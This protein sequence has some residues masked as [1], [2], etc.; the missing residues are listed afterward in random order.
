MAGHSP[1]P[2]LSDWC[3]VLPPSTRDVDRV[4]PTVD[5]RGLNALR[6]REHADRSIRI[7]PRRSI[8]ARRRR[9]RR[10]RG[11]RHGVG[12]GGRA[13]DQIVEERQLRDDSQVVRNVN[14][15]IE[16]EPEIRTR[17]RLVVAGLVRGRCVAADVDRLSRVSVRLAVAVVERGG[18]E[19]GGVVARDVPVDCRALEGGIPTSEHEVMEKLGARSKISVEFNH[20]TRMPPP[21]V[22]KDLVGVWRHVLSGRATGGLPGS[23]VLRRCGMT[24]SRRSRFAP[25]RTHRRMRRFAAPLELPG[26]RGRLSRCRR[27]R[28]LGGSGFTGRGWRWRRRDRGLFRGCCPREKDERG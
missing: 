18:E 9:G 26:S 23:I 20:G 24:R 12:I 11:R 27:R 5:A 28:L 22:A 7:A 8:T 10:A 21:R 15:G 3:F 4:R 17:F 1:K 19:I 25:A 13:Q 2:Q 14:L 16:A 6:R